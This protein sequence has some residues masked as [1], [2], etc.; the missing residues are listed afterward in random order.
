MKIISEFGFVFHR[1]I[2]VVFNTK[3]EKMLIFSIV[4]GSPLREDRV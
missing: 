4:K 2:V 1:K 3:I